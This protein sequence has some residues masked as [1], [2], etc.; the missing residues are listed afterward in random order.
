MNISVIFIFISSL[1][2]LNGE[3]ASSEECVVIFLEQI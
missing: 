2:N 1:L 3:A